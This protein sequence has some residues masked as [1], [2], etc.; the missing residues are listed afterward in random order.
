MRLIK[1]LA[2]GLCSLGF[3]YLVLNSFSFTASLADNQRLPDLDPIE[4]FSLF[5]QNQNKFTEKNLDGSIWVVSFMF[6]CCKGPCP[7][8]TRNL[9]K[10]QKKLLNFD[11]ISFLT[12]SMQPKKDDPSRLRSYVEKHHP[13]FKRWFFLTGDQKHIIDVSQKQFRV[14]ASMQSD[15]HSTRFLI[16]NSER[17]IVSYYDGTDPKSI[18]RIVFDVKRLLSKSSV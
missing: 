7:L 5:D 13:D 4:R 2:V 12:F 16:L 11:K 17:K 14:P 15:A 1:Y 18:D 6:T 10:I 8:L 9:V 3:V